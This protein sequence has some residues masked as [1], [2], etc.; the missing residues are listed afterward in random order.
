MAT[1]SSTVTLVDNMTS[2]LN[3]IRDAVEEVQT[4]LNNISGEQD[5]LDKFSWSTFLSNAEAAGKKMAK[6]GQQMTLAMTAPLVVLGK[7]MYGGAT[8]YESAYVGM[9][10]TVDGTEE[11][12]E[13]LNETALHLSETTPMNYVDLMGIAQTGGNLGVK[14]DEMEAFLQGYSALQYATDQHISGETGAQLVADFLNITE[15]GVGKI[16]QFGSAIVHL[17][18]NFNATEDQILGMGKRMAAAG[19]L[20]NLTT[21]EILGMAT[22]FRSVGINEEAGGSAASKLIKQF[23]LSAEVGGKAQAQL[24]AVGQQWESGIDFSNYLAGIKKADL[25][26][27]AES[28]GT[29]TDAV[30][31]MADSWVLLDQFAEVSGKTSSQFIDDWSKSPAQAMSDFF[32]GLNR[33]GDQ[34][35]DSI[36]STLDKMGLTEIRESNLIAAMASRPELFASAIQ[37]AVQAY[38]SNTAMMD[39]FE[40]QMGTQESQNAMLGN[41]LSNTMADFGQNLV[42]ALQPALDL[43]NDLLDKFNSLSETDQTHI[44]ELLGALA[45]AGPT[46]VG[47]G[48]TVEAVTSIAI[49]IEKIKNS[50]KAKAVIE[51]VIGLL[52][53]PVGGALMVA[54]AIAAIAAAIE[55]IPTESE[56]I[57]ESLKDIEITVDEE[58]V[59]ETLAAIRKVREEAETLKNPEISADFENRSAAVAMGYG[60]NTMYGDAL[61]YEAIKTNSEIDAMI[62]DYSGKM[63]EAESQIANATTDADREYWFGEYGRLE[64]EMNAAVAE[65][66]QLYSE[67][68]SEL[69]NGMAARYPEAAAALEKASKQYDL[70]AA[71]QRVQDFDVWNMPVPENWGKMS[72]AEQDQY[73]SD[74]YAK[75][76]A[77]ESDVMRLASELGYIDMSYEE[78]VGHLTNLYDGQNYDSLTAG[79]WDKLQKDMASSV[80]TVSENPLLAGF[81]KSITSDEAVLQNMDFSSLQ[82]AFAGIIKTLDYSEAMKQA[83]EA[84]NV[85]SFGEYLTQGLA[86]GITETT[87]VGTQAA[88]AFGTA[89]V[90][91]LASAL[92]VSSPSIYAIQDGMYM[93]MGLA[94]GITSNQGMVTSAMSAVCNQVVAIGNSIV[95]HGAGYSMGRNIGLGLAAGIRSQIGA[96]RAAASALASAAAISAQ[97]RLGIHSPSRV[98]YGFG[99]YTGIGFVNGIL[100]NRKDAASA[101]GK[102]VSA[103]ESAWNTAAWSDIA[104][105]AGLEHDS[106]LDDAK[107]AVKISDSDIRKIRDLAER[108]VINRFT[109][110]KVEIQMHNTNEIKSNMDLDGIVDYLGDK[111]SERLEAVA[112]GVYA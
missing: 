85:N 63:R 108:E 17:G 24:E 112:E 88:S 53:T 104:L 22:A 59:N 76:V 64:S 25:V 20:A 2:K 96:V 15:G 92:G 79:L 72:M 35:T 23:Q 58:S 34:G 93:D 86:N 31:S 43:V 71:I 13:R 106:L 28:M 42:E 73:E 68:V 21:P 97:T 69:F 80:Q 105:F 40:K 45:I 29:T 82:G 101:M 61:G 4:S 103:T 19:H 56:K 10:K 37:A 30:Q 111:V 102:I 110:A 99:D 89:V 55:S 9:K 39:E 44:V 51:K 66:K 16:A 70:M 1:I 60:T 52:G 12:Y 109:T 5:S 14:I 91:M 8:D 95:N 87:D 47:V 75:A 81:L 49:G 7:K 77:V 65:R 78:A 11:Q 57:W 48:K 62:A 100:A 94:Q 83:A 84:G 54:G 50:S 32:Y 107:D 18:N 38:T 67:K 3:T 33:L 36:L 41:K 74:W 26:A 90:N 46:L 98:F 27:L 6:I